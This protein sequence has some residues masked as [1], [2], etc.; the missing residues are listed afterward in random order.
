[1]KLTKLYKDPESGRTGCPTVYVADS[2]E[3]VVQ[4]YEI[5][6][7]THAQLENI[8]PGETA[9]RISPEILQGAIERYRKV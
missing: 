8:L 1:M 5:D 7:D 3:L 2:G 9:V 6:S 4:G